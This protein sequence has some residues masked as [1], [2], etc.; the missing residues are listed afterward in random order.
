M[1]TEKFFIADPFNDEHLALFTKFEIENGINTKSA[2][3]MQE[4]RKTTTQEAYLKSLKEKNEINQS[5]FLQDGPKLKDSCH[6]QGEKDIK[7]CNIS[8]AP[9]PF[10]T[11]NRHLL[12]LVID[13]AFNVLGMEDIFVSISPTDT[14]LKENLLLQGFESLGELNGNITYLKE[15]ELEKEESLV[16]NI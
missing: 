5:L 14:Y 6:V 2:S 12:S 11:K 15:K 9:V 13:Y 10:K 8:F 4:I 7:S 3:Y 1:S 16:Q